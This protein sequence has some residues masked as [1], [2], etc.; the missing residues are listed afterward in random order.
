MKTL[1]YFL[2]LS[3]LGSLLLTSC[4]TANKQLEAEL[5][6]SDK[7]TIMYYK[8]GDAS[9]P[10]RSFQVMADT[11]EDIKMTI[12]YLTSSSSDAMECPSNGIMRFFKGEE[13][14]FSSEFSIDN[15]CASYTQNGE[16]LTINKAGKDY[17]NKYYE[18]AKKLN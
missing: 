6:G 18:T 12:S 13:E 14:L 1:Q 2:T 8:D 9:K 10:I 5:A 16:T 15:N 11:P 3:L 7:M 17:L 4:E